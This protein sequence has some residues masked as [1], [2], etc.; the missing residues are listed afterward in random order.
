MFA[1]G[2]VAEQPQ[3]ERPIPQLGEEEGPEPRVL[4]TPIA[5]TLQD[6][7]SQLVMRTC[8]C[9]WRKD[10]GEDLM[11]RTREKEEVFAVQKQRVLKGFTRLGF[12]IYKLIASKFRTQVWSDQ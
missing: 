7:Q 6:L 12:R 11:T 3:A 2:E 5:E 4:S 1:P 9:Q 8:R 10:Y